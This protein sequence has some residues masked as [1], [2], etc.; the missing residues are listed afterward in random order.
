MRGLKKRHGRLLNRMSSPCIHI[1]EK[2]LTTCAAISC[3]DVA[4]VCLTIH[5]RLGGFPAIIHHF[6]SFE[7]T[8]A[9]SVIISL[10]DVCISYVIFKFTARLIAFART[11]P[12]ESPRDEHRRG[13]P[14]SPVPSLLDGCLESFYLC[15]SLS[16]LTR[17]CNRSVRPTVP[18][19]SRPRFHRVGRSRTW[20]SRFYL[21]PGSGT[22]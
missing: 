21:D 9:K 13:R 11:T 4:S 3:V 7:P 5:L 1:S 17:E 19:S 20:T 12:H 18:V 16:T 10:L 14:F 2:I 22:V 6:Y 15:I 8:L